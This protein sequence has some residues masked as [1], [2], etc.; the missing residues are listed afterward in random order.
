MEV[1]A[2][3]A[4]LVV[5]ADVKR[6][7]EEKKKGAHSLSCS[8]QSQKSVRVPADKLVGLG[9]PG[10]DVKEGVVILRASHTLCRCSSTQVAG[11]M[12]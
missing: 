11:A 9:T 12:W 8:S 1:K 10:T 5:G 3:Q 7:L 6:E 2:V 4:F